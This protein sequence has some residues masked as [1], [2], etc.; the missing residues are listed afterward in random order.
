VGQQRSQRD[1]LERCIGYVLADMAVQLESAVLDQPEHDC[2]R[3]SLRDRSDP[4]RR[5]WVGGDGPLDVGQPCRRETE[6]L[7]STAC[8]EHHAGDS[9]P[10]LLP[11]GPPPQHLTRHVQPVPPLGRHVL[12]RSWVPSAPPSTGAVD[13]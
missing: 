1:P 10:G 13:R 6:R 12:K 9:A 4:I 11:H 3:E 8:S 7:S 5:M 2:R